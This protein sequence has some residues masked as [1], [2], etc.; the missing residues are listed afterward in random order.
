MQKSA[1]LKRSLGLW[2]IVML[3]VG[4][5]TPM[6]VFDTFGIASDEANGHVPLAYVI[7]LAAMLFTAFSYGRMV[8]AFPSAGSAYTYTQKSINPH[9]GFVVGW[10]SL[11]DYLLLPMVNVLLTQI[12]LSALFPTVPAWVWVVGFVAVV[13]FMN[14][15]GVTSM[16]NLN[17]FLVVYQILVVA[18]FVVLAIRELLGGAGY[19]TAFPTEPF[20]TPDMQISALIVG[21]TVLCFSFLGFDAVTTYAEET[22]NPVKTIPRAIFLTALIGGL[23]FIV[24]SYF[25]QAVFPDISRFK[26]PDATSP[27]I[28]LYVGGKFFQWFFLAGA[29]AGTIASGMASHASVSRLLYVMGRDNILPKRLFGYVHPRTHT[30][31]YNVILVGLIS[32]TAVFFTLEI[33]SSF[34]SFGA[35]IAF[36]F[37]NL[38]VVAHYAVKNKQYKTFGNL[39]SN[40]IIPLIGAAFVAVLWYNLES[41]SFM[42]GMIWFT[43][44]VVYLAFVTKMFRVQP[45]DIH[46]EE[47]DESSYIDEEDSVVT[48][49]RSS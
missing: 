16:S 8:R 12:Y 13:T 34:I 25:T 44:G 1:S 36:T 2:P 29:L 24:A 15:V 10:S 6:V 26:N 3:G 9:L 22:P 19:G 38:S 35:L 11:L 33:A 42:M 40:V 41:S 28:A 5:M 49:Q 32:L 14:V 18:I 43:L 30:P 48:G 21:A 37:V 23:I 31:I 45:M 47:A 27:E 7:A 4:Y 46:F 17:T 39:L 20:Y